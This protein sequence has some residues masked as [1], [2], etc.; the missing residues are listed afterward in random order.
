MTCLIRPSLTDPDD[1]CQGMLSQGLPN[2]E[3]L[4]SRDTG[5]WDVYMKL[6][7]LEFTF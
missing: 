7:V 2:F 5:I 1:F 4:V 6:V 3:I